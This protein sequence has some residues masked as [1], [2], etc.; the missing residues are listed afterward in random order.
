MPPLNT[1]KYRIHKVQQFMLETMKDL[2]VF[3]TARNSMARGRGSSFGAIE[4]RC[5]KAELYPQTF[6]QVIADLW[7]RRE[8]VGTG[9]SRLG[10]ERWSYGTHQ[11]PLKEESVACSSQSLPAV[12]LME[13]CP[14]EEI[15]HTLQSTG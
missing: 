1:T 3:S 4:Q 6:S 12:A 10:W 14:Q 9:S 5:L 11:R 15:K 8:L 13:F 7:K 2:P